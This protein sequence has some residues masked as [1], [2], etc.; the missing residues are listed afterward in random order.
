MKTLTLLLSAAA[1]T[2]FGFPSVSDV[3]ISADSAARRVTVNY[4]LADGPAIITAEFLT[5]GVPLNAALCACVY[6][7]VNKRVTNGVH[8]LVWLVDHSGFNAR[9]DDAAVT[10]RMKAWPLETPPDYLVVGLDGPNDVRYFTSTNALPGG[11]AN[12]DYR[13]RYLVMRKIPAAGARRRLG[14][15]PGETGPF[16]AGSGSTAG[17]DTRSRET[18]R[19]VSFTNDFWMGVYPV[20]QAQWGRIRPDLNPSN[21]KTGSDASLR[22]VEQV[23]YG[24][25]R[26]TTWPTDGHVFTASDESSCW[27][28]R[29]RARSGIAFDLPTDAQWEFAAR[30][31]CDTSLYNGTGVSV[32]NEA[33]DAALDKLGWFVANANGTTHPVG[34]K[35]PNNWGLYDVLGNVWELVLDKGDTTGATIAGDETVD[36]P[37]SASCSNPG[38]CKRGGGWYSPA[39]QCRCAIRGAENETFTNYGTGFR[40]MAPIGLVW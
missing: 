7:D 5:N 21:F 32:M 39:R 4:T 29:L 33:F 35:L 37:G 14:Y 34:L 23:K 12:D 11:L 20:T 3:T 16:L 9:L 15:Q 36:P 31:G 17:I 18:P 2:A 24:D 1:L 6:G 38:R 8:E 10:A 28:A 27:I 30:A 40:L 19:M 13:T 22:P 26:P 25:V